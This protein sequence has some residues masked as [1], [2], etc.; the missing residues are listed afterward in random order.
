[1]KYVKGERALHK[2]IS[3]EITYAWG[4]PFKVESDISREEEENGKEFF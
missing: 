1:M 2:E 4:Y 3:K